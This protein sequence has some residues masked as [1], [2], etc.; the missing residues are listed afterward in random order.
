MT[1]DY[2]VIV[3]GAGVVGSAVAH[4][5]GQQGRNVLLIERDWQEPDRIVGELLQ[6]GGVHALERLGMEDCIKDIDGIRVDGYAV[7]QREREV[8]L[9]Y[10]NPELNKGISFHHGKFIMQLRR[11]ARE[12]NMVTCL[13][14]TVNELLTCQAT[15]VRLGVQV[16]R[17]QDN[18]SIKESYFAPLTVVADGC[19]SKFRREFIDKPIPAKSHFVGFV[20]KDCKLPHPNHGHVILADPSPIL[21]YQIGTH[22]TRILVD[23]PGKLP[24]SGNGEMLKYMKEKVGPQLP[25]SVQESFYQAVETERFR[26]MPNSWLPPSQNRSEGVILLGDA[27]NMR[28]PLTGGGMTVG[29]WDAVKLVEGLEDLKTFEETKI[30]TTRAAQ[31]HWQR[32]GLSSVVNILANALYE[33]FSA[34]DDPRLKE[35]QEACFGYFELGGICVSTPVSLLAGIMPEPMTL[36][37]H[38]FAVAFY[39]MVR[40][41]AKNPIYMLPYSFVSGILVLYQAAIVILPLLAAET[42]I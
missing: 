30:V 32:K 21:L 23:I 9:P 19:F 28:H 33:L 10:P 6:P 22:D 34:G 18:Q 36:V 16:T 17:K 20:L 29:L 14:G 8:V 31:L 13:E 7:F 11:K 4:A 42:G 35:L 40:M 1:R 26:S 15:G 3:V 41:C 5:L 24:S 37:K 38:F 27:Q 25:K 2:D 39:A 12:N